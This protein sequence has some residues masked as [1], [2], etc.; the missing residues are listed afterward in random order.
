MV[1][2]P[3]APIFVRCTKRILPVQGKNSGL[4]CIMKK[5]EG[6]EPIEDANQRVSL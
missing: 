1:S 5:E 6:T 4:S 2:P 3:A